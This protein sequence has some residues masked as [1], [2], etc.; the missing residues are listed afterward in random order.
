MRK[1]MLTMSIAL[2]LSV[3]GAFAQTAPAE[4]TDAGKSEIKKDT[5]AP[6]KAVAV[7]QAKKKAA[8]GAKVKGNKA[9]VKKHEDEIRAHDATKAEVKEHA[10]DAKAA[11]GKS[12]K[13]KVAAHKDEIKQ[14]ADSKQE[15]KAK[16]QRKHDKKGE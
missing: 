12:K 16:L 6:R 4:K 9:K 13:E 8:M 3:S 14:H 7:D 1:L 15:A 11:D 5:P 2:V 10:A